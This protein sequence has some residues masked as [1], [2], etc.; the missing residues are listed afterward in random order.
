MFDQTITL[1]NYRISEGAWHA[2]VFHG[3]NVLQQRADTATTQGTDNA[4]AAEFLLQCDAGQRAEGLQYAPPKAYQ[5][6]EDASGY[7]T[8]TPQA[9][10]IA[11]GAHDADAPVP[12]SDYAEGLYQTMNEL[13]DGVVQITTAAWFSLLPHFEIGGK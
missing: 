10:F 12:E 8:L 4:D 13:Y 1:F 5:A 7:F 9:D 2:H 11:I 6:L 3:V